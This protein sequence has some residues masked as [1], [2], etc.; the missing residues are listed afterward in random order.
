MAQVGPGELSR[1][2]GEM[3]YWPHR[4]SPGEGKGYGA[5]Q[6]I[7][8]R[9]ALALHPAI[10]QSGMPPRRLWLKPLGEMRGIP[11]EA[12]AAGALLYPRLRVPVPRRPVPRGRGGYSRR[13]QARR[14]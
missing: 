13:R 14:S 7:A 8:L 2:M 12:P 1:A 3:L 11:G 6:Y 4:L 10:W 5:Y 9:G